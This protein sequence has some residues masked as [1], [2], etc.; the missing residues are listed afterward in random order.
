VS[1]QVRSCR[2]VN[3]HHPTGYRSG[4]K[5]SGGPFERSEHHSLLHTMNASQMAPIQTSSQNSKRHHSQQ[6]LN[7]L[8]NF[9]LP[10]RVQ[11]APPLPR[12]T[13][14]PIKSQAWNKDKFINAQYRFVM[15]PTGDYTVHFADPD[16]YFHWQD[17]LQVI[18]TRPP[19][20]DS[21]SDHEGAANCPICLSPST[22]PRITKCGHVSV[23]LRLLYSVLMWRDRC[24]AIPV[25]CITWKWARIPSG[26]DAQY[27]LKP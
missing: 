27:A 2:L 9:T 21:G 7:H 16:I 11:H 26:V 14:R 8:L 24:F 12:R 22:A 17:I 19:I 5:K 25:Y 10:P 1:L 4:C 20:D 13:K 18:M 23:I 15:R 6:S 3:Y